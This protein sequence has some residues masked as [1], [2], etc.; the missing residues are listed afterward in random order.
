MIKVDG[1]RSCA[2]RFLKPLAATVLDVDVWRRQRINLP[3]GQVS[4]D[5][6]QTLP[7]ELPSRFYGVSRSTFHHISEDWT[8]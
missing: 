5:E 4:I 3:D 1:R 2:D 7:A 8:S 6:I